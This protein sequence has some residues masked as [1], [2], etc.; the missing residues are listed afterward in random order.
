MKKTDIFKTNRAA[1]AGKISTEQYERFHIHFAKE[2]ANDEIEND[3][4]VNDYLTEQ[5]A[6]FDEKTF[7]DSN[8]EQKKYYADKDIQLKDEHDK[9]TYANL[10]QYKRDAQVNQDAMSKYIARQRQALAKAIV[11][12][13]NLKKDYLTKHAELKKLQQKFVAISNRQTLLEE[14]SIELKVKAEA[15]TEQ[16]KQAIASIN[17]K[18]NKDDSKHFEIKTDA[19]IHVADYALQRDRQFAQKC[20]IMS[21]E[22]EQANDLD[23]KDKISLEIERLKASYAIMQNE[24]IQSLTQVS[25]SMQINQHKD[26]LD[27]VSQ[28]IAEVELKLEAKNIKVDFTFEGKVV[29]VREISEQE[30]I[31]HELSRDLNTIKQSELVNDDFFKS[32]AEL[33]HNQQTIQSDYKKMNTLAKEVSLDRNKLEQKERQVDAIKS[34]MIDRIKAQREHSSRI[35][36]NLKGLSIGSKTDNLQTEA[37][38]NQKS[39]IQLQQKLSENHVRAM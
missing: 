23:V 26:R 13:N 12:K 27:N 36:S 29:D 3:K 5:L 39:R 25:R 20:E 17:N 4:K 1:E 22:M 18:F 24:K 38:D 10:A 9:Q 2:F 33:H 11:E 34:N 14:R 37:R 21:D 16:E 28:R 15:L 32:S 31:G 7:F 19:L 8:D 6:E 35:N 30:K